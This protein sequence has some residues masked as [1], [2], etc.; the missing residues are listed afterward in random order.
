MSVLHMELGCSDPHPPN[1]G[2]LYTMVQTPIPL[3]QG[4]CNILIFYTFSCIK[5]K[6][7][8]EIF[9]DYEFFLNFAYC[10]ICR[11]NLK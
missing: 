5:M 8:A 4:A 9:R 6:K 10:N 11:L 1:S 3:T 2:G 7:Y